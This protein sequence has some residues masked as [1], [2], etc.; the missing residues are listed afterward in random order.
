MMGLATPAWVMVMMAV[1]AALF[2]LFAVATATFFVIREVA[3]EKERKRRKRKRKERWP[4]QGCK[5]R[6]MK[7]VLMLSCLMDLVRSVPV[8]QSSIQSAVNDWIA[9]GTVKENVKATYGEIKE[10]DTSEITNMEDLLINAYDKIN[11][12]C[13][14]NGDVSAWDVSKVE[15]MAGSTFDS[16]STITVTPVLVPLLRFNFFFL[17]PPPCLLLIHLFFFPLS[18]FFFFSLQHL[19]NALA[20]TRIF[21]SGSSPKSPTWTKVGVAPSII[22]HFYFYIFSPTLAVPCAFC[23]SSSHINIK[24]PN[25]SF[26]L[27]SSIFRGQ[28]VQC[29]P[30]NMGRL[31]GHHNGQDVRRDQQLCAL[32]LW[33]DLDQKQS[34]KNFHVLG[35]RRLHR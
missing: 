35:I 29:R 22:H 30:F 16:T 18:F 6:K 24:I 11:E 5:E 4:E 21:Q 23:C 7:L 28:R 14:F 3:S 33:C 2:A 26:P 8:P 32:T 27:S 13:T 9:G 12:P 25:S 10:W 15:T 19:K 17:V 34:H 1:S 31:E 20:S